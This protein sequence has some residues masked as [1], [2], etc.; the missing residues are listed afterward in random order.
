MKFGLEDRHWIFLN[1]SLIQ[2]LKDHGS[3]IWIFGSR[4]QG[5]HRSFSDV[6]ILYSIDHELPAYFVGG[7][8][9]RIENSN[10]P[11]KVDLVLERDLADSYRAGVFATRIEI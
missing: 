11:F 4:A 8:L 1:E 7:A 3:K 10:F 9:E 6:D 2:P 5:T